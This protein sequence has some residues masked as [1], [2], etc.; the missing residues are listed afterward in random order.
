MIKIAIYALIL[1][2]SFS[3]SNRVDQTIGGYI[4]IPYHQWI[5][6]VVLF[7]VGVF[8]YKKFKKIFLIFLIIGAIIVAFD[9]RDM[10]SLEYWG[11]DGPLR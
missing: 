11:I 5:Y 4:G 9:F 1:F 8:L 6:V 7:V 2:V 3:I 10:L